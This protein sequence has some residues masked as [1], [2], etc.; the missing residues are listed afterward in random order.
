MVSD[1]ENFEAWHARIL[2]S[3]YE[4]RDAGISIVTLAFPLLERYVRQK[5]QL[6]SA[7]SLKDAFYEEVSRLIPGFQQA[8]A[9]QFWSA[10]RNGLLHQVTLELETRGGA[11]FTAMRADS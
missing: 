11:A 6:P 8:Q 9:K 10:V 5:I 2:E 1:R 3:L 4:T 7:E